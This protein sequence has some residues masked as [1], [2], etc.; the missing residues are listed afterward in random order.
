MVNFHFRK[1]GAGI[2]T[3]KEIM[4]RN[5]LIPLAVA[6]LFAFNPLPQPVAHAQ[7]DVTY[8]GNKNSKKFH[9]PTCRWAKRIKTTNVVVFKSRKEATDAGYVTCKVCKP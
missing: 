7:S 9:R 1:V 4:K 3:A 5:L 8:V 6:L 2:P